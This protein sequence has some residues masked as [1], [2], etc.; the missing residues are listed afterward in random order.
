MALNNEKCLA[1]LHAWT[2]LRLAFHGAINAGLCLAAA[3]NVEGCR[4]ITWQQGLTKRFQASPNYMQRLET[5]REQ[6]PET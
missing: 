3:C 1:R 6:V 5:I 4:I 2:I